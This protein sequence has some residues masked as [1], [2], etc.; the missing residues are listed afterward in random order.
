MRH[1]Y[2][3][4]TTSEQLAWIKVAASHHAQH[5]PHAMLRDVVTVEDV[6]NSPMISDPLHRLDCCV[7]SDGGGAMVVVAPEIAAQLK[8]PKVKLMGAGEAIKHMNGGKVDLS[9]SG[10]PGRRPRPSP[11]PASSRPTSSTPRST[12]AS[13]S[14]C[15]CS[16]KTRLLR[17]GPGRTLS[18]PMAASSP[19]SASCRSTPMAAACATTIPANRGG[20]TKVLEAVRQLRGEAH[21]GAGEKLRS[22]A[23]ARHR[24]LARYAPR[25]RT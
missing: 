3:H 6:V 13:P 18:W 16:S 1:M 9:Y 7:V 14:R 25:Q 21:P 20:M 17:E 22:G 12:T 8:R 2:D 15:S 10:G 5:N 24:W 4:G 11:K 19:A 23:G